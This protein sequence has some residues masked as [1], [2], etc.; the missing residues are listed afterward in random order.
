MPRCLQKF[1][2]STKKTSIVMVLF[3]P[4]NGGGSTSLP[5]CV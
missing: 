1:C 4:G 2:S 3:G 5:T